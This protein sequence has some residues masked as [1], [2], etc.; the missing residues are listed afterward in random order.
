MEKQKVNKEFVIKVPSKCSTIEL[1]AFEKMVIT[2]GEV[3]KSNLKQK[4]LNAQ[5]LLFYYEAAQLCGTAAIKTHNSEY[6][7]KIVHAASISEK[8]DN[9]INEIGWIYICPS[10]R[11]KKLSLEFVKRL[12]DG[13]SKQIYS[14]VREENIAM[15]KTLLNAG[16]SKLGNPYKSSRGSYKLEFYLKNGNTTVDI[17]K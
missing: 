11:G 13:Y 8:L 12:L 5:L 1:T 9:T 2:G 6:F 14:T 3:T 4:I 15:K 16:F 10:Q 7:N 17:Y